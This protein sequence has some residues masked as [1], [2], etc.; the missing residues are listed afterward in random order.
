MQ[1]KCHTTHNDVKQCVYRGWR[2]KIFQSPCTF[3]GHG[4]MIKAKIF[5]MRPKFSPLMTDYNLF[6]RLHRHTRRGGGGGGVQPH[7]TSRTF[8]EA[9]FG[10]N[11]LYSGKTTWFWDKQCRT[12][13]AQETSAPN[14]TGP[15]CLWSITTSPFI[16]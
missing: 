3:E 13:F 8:Q 5:K 1:Y 7:P 11:K 15:V 2:A 14:E 16:L 9:I 10:Q 4:G 6:G 12:L